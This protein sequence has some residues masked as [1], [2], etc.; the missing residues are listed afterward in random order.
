MPAQ[1]QIPA[2]LGDALLA[3]IAT[4]QQFLNANPPAL[5]K[6]G[7]FTS[8]IDEVVTARDLHFVQV[9]VNALAHFKEVLLESLREAHSQDHPWH[10]LQLTAEERLARSEADGCFNRVRRFLVRT[11]QSKGADNCSKQPGVRGRPSGSPT[12]ERDNKLYADWIAA[13]ALTGMSK[14]EFLR[15]RG[16][17]QSDGAAIERGRGNAKR[18]RKGRK[19]LDEIGQA[20]SI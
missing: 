17:P 16:L 8:A 7:E 18:K 11:C 19:S 13:H 4:A 3:A 2:R 1:N 6:L 15:E 12:A 20:L 10:W 9:D 14:A 5:S